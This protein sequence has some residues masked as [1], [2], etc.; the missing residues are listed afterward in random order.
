MSCTPDRAH[1]VAA[2]TYI[3][4][5]CRLIEAAAQESGLDRDFFARLLWKESLFDAAAVSPAGAQGIAQFMP[6]TA[7]LR[8]LGDAF[9]PAEALVASARYLSELSR[10]W[11]TSASRRSP[12]TAARRGR[13]ASSPPRPACRSR[14]APMS[15]DHRP[16]GRDLARRA[17]GVGRPRARQGGGDFQA[18]CIA[19]AEARS[20]REPRAPVLPWG[21]IVASNRDGAGAERQVARLQNRY[22]AILRGETVAYTSGRR[23]GC[24]PGCMSRRSAAAAAPRPRRSAPGC[25][26][27]AATAWC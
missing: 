12:T 11:A 5:V 22:A 1:C 13:R 9:N 19:R 6:E 14:P 18:A 25:A 4:D 10:D 23:P 24:R 8:G 16:L 27:P 15:R 2:A 17:A 3:P 20:L 21:V 7:K 26:P